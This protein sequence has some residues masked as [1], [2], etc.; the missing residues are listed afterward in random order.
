M[1][2]DWTTSAFAQLKEK[3]LTSHPLNKKRLEN[4]KW[5]QATFVPARPRRS[6]TGNIIKHH[7]ELHLENNLDLNKFY[8]VLN[9]TL[10]ETTPDLR[11]RTAARMECLSARPRHTGGGQ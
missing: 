10:E 6:M 7:G 9:L 3:E 2:R 1:K 8:F 5:A 4:S 11:R